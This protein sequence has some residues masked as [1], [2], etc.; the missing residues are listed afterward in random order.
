M[1]NIYPIVAQMPPPSANHAIVALYTYSPRLN[2]ASGI[3]TGNKPSLETYPMQTCLDT[4]MFSVTSFNIFIKYR[5]FSSEITH[6]EITILR[7]PSTYDEAYMQYACS[8]V[9]ASL[10]PLPKCCLSRVSHV[11]CYASHKLTVIAQ[12]M[13]R[14]LASKIAQYHLFL[15]VMF[16]LFS[17]RSSGCNALQLQQYTAIRAEVQHS[18][19]TR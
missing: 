16:L 17:T 11:A 7:F 8:L 13:R 15:V 5:W 6:T 12:P 18:F 9:C 10:F 14:A 1:S 4:H 3:K 19:L 2:N